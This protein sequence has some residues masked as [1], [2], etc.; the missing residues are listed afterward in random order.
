MDQQQQQPSSQT[1]HKEN[2]LPKKSRKSH[3]PAG[4]SLHAAGTSAGA[5]GYKKGDSAGGLSSSLSFDGGS[6]QT[7]QSSAI[8]VVEV[9]QQNCYKKEKDF[10]DVIPL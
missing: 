2:R 8:Q 5:T 1:T 3:T 6:M 9:R 4:L 7:Q 10:F